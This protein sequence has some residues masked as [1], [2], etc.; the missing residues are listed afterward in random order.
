VGVSVSSKVSWGCN[1]SSNGN[2]GTS[3]SCTSISYGTSSIGGWNGS[4]SCTC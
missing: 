1:T 2:S 3:I 4:N